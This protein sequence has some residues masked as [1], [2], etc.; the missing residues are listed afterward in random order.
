MIYSLVSTLLV[1]GK[2]SEYYEISPKELVPLFS[3]LGM[4]LSGS[5][6]ALTGN[7]NEM[8]TLNAFKDLAE[9]QKGIEAQKNNDDWQRVNAKVNT[10]RVSQTMTL[11]EPNPWSPMK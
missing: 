7:M 2:M 8:Y 9:F 1:P 11:L 6:R 4:Q 10:L 3:K 5:F